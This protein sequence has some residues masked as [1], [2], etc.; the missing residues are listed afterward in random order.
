M[1]YVLTVFLFGR[2]FVL[3]PNLTASDCEVYNQQLSAPF[4]CVREVAI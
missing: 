2:I 4:S 3:D 1:T